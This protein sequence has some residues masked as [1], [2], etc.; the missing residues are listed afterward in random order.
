[1]GAIVRKLENGEMEFENEELDI[2]K[3]RE[4]KRSY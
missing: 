1:L 2:G 4:M 3:W